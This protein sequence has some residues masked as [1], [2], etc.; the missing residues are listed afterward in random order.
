MLKHAYLRA[1]GRYD[2]YDVEPKIVT[3][4]EYAAMKKREE[5]RAQKERLMIAR[6]EIDAQLAEV[7]KQLDTLVVPSTESVE[8]ASVAVDPGNSSTEATT[9]RKW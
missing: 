3:A 4:A 9:K 5:L 6:N 7:D 1:D 8:A 2:M